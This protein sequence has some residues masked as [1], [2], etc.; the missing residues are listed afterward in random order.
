MLTIITRVRL[1]GDASECW[2]EAMRRRVETAKDCQG[3]VAAQVV[4]GS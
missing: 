1:R 3:W 4:E 2:D